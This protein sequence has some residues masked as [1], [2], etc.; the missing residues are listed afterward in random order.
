M[1]SYNETNKRGFGVKSKNFFHSSLLFAALFIL[2]A[3]PLTAQTGSTSALT[4]R[5]TDTTGA[6]LPGVTGTATAIATNQSRTVVSA[7]DGV[8]RIPLLDPG[9]Y[10]VRF[11]APGFKTKDVMSV[12]LNVTETFALDQTLEVG[13]PTEEVT[14]EAV[15]E[16][17]QTATST[18]GTTVTGSQITNFPLSARNFTAVLGLSSGVAVDVSNATSFGRGSLNMSVNGAN[19]E[20]NNFQMDGVAIN[21]GSKQAVSTQMSAHAP[22]S[23]ASQRGFLPQ[24]QSLAQNALHGHRSGGRR[25]YLL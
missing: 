12:T 6:V 23:E 25:R 22:S 21:N 1:R 20:K 15:A 17:I 14:V 18:I 19:P 11:A 8:Y 9:D 3:S 4:G 24:A 10:R 7:E 5:I 13:A 2:T 16:T